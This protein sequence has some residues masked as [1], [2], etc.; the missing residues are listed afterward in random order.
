MTEQVAFI[1]RVSVAIS[2]IHNE[3][4]CRTRRIGDS[5]PRRYYICLR[6]E[7]TGLKRLCKLVQLD[8]RPL[9]KLSD[10]TR[11]S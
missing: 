4:Y 11:D 1:G 7:V 8:S 5:L 2:S 10:I 9:Q 3:G 6:P